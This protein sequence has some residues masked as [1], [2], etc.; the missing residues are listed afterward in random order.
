ME[1]PV[2]QFKANCTRLLRE[3]SEPIHITNRGRVIAVVN[4]PALAEG[5][6]PVVG[7][8]EARI[9]Y[10]AGWDAPLGDEDWEAAQ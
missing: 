2:S 1:M 4:P 6:N 9:T 3:L 8:M 5:R 7:C 10:R